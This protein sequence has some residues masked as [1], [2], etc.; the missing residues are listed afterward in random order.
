MPA[1]ASAAAASPR[2]SA[3]LGPVSELG[4]DSTMRFLNEVDE[5]NLRPRTRAVYVTETLLGSLEGGRSPPRR[6]LQAQQQRQ[7][8]PAL[9]VATRSTTAA[10][11]SASTTRGQRERVR[12][13]A[14][15]L[16]RCP[17]TA[18]A[19]ADLVML[20]ASNPIRQH[21]P[22]R[23][24]QRRLPQ[25]IVDERNVLDHDHDHGRLGH[26]LPS[27]ASELLKVPAAL[28]DFPR[29]TSSARLRLAR[30]PRPG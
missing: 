7:D 29:K 20:L 5:V 25:R 9:D 11:T 10:P 14:P 16:R 17:A 15:E 18:V 12:R 22:G 24:V 1:S 26:R 27:A 8:S 4:L 19:D 28:S 2:T 6:R 13:T 21:G 3:P 23:A 30:H